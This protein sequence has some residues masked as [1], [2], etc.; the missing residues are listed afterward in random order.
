MGDQD[1]NIELVANDSIVVHSVSSM[2]Y[3]NNV[4]IEGHVLMLEINLFEKV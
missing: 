4:R 3:S 2:L 1:H